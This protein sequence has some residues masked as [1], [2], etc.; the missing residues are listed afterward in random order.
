MRKWLRKLRGML[1]TATIWGGCGA[2]LGAALGAITG[3]LNGGGLLAWALDGFLQL[4]ALGFAV[5]AGFAALL[6]ALDG[7]RRLLELSPLRGALWGGSAGLTLSSLAW[8]A[9]GT[10]V[11][12]PA[13]LV[14]SG[15]GALL[16]SGSVVIAR[17]HLPELAPG[18][19]PS[20]EFLL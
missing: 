10:S 3:A 13:V 4:G 11:S 1:G 2:V 17:S 6:S 20:E 18:S 9:V 15:L 7:G 14:T 19:Q 5:G 16:G 8:I 12:W